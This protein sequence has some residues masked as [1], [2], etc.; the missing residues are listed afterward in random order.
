MGAWSMDRGGPFS[1]D[2]VDAVVAYLRTF[3]TVPSVTLDPAP[4]AGDPARAEP[5]YQAQCQSCHGDQGENGRYVEI[6]NPEFLASANDAYVRAAIVDGR[7]G[8]PMAAFGTALP[9]SSIDDLV[10]LVRS[11][12]RP[13][14]GPETLPPGPGALTDVVVNPGGP[15]PGF[16]PAAQFV[17]VDTV[18]AA[19]DV[20]ASFVLSDARLPSDY[21]GNHIAGAINVPFYQVESFLSQIPKDKYIITYCGCPH[22]ESGQAAAVYRANGY[23]RVAV[24]DEGFDVWRSRGYPVRSGGAP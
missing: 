17:P 2:D 10:A 6:G 24:L 1:G 20:G 8:T 12:Q 19:L 11:W 9:S 16:D 23:A 15:D 3:Q 22:A 18:K 13:V 4:I 21:S 5:V 7:S 14:D